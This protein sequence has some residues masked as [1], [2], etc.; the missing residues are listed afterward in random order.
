MKLSCVDAITP[1][2]SFREKFEILEK[3]GFE[4]IEIWAMEDDDLTAS[5]MT[6]LC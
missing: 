3:Y 6:R 4:G 1:G 2:V 5:W